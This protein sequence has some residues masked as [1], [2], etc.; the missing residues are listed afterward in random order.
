MIPRQTGKSFTLAD[1]LFQKYIEDGEQG[2]NYLMMSPQENKVKNLLIDDIMLEPFGGQEVLSDINSVYI[3][4]PDNFVKRKYKEWQENPDV[5]DNLIQQGLITDDLQYTKLFWG[6][7]ANTGKGS[8]EQ[9]HYNGRLFNGAELTLAGANNPN[10]SNILRGKKWKGVYIAE[11]GEVEKDIMSIFMPSVIK[12]GGWFWFDGTPPNR[13]KGNQ[14][15]YFK[16]IEPIVKNQNVKLAK[17]FGVSFYN[18][19][20]TLEIAQTTAEIM[21]GLEPRKITDRRMLAIGKLEDLFPY[22]W[23]G[24]EYFTR[25]QSSRKVPLTIDYLKDKDGNY[26]E[27]VENSYTDPKTK[28]RVVFYKYNLKP[29]PINTSGLA[30]MDESEYNREMQ[31]SFTDF[32]QQTF[33]LFSEANVIPHELFNP[34]IYNCFT[35]FDQGVN[36]NFVM[37]NPLGTHSATCIV[38]IALI[39][40]GRFYQYV[41][42][43]Y[44]YIEKPSKYNIAR[45][46]LDTLKAGKPIVLDNAILKSL[47]SDNLSVFNAIIESDDDLYN[48]SEARINKGIYKCIKR[49]SYSKAKEYNTWF[50]QTQVTDLTQETY[51]HPTDASQIGRKIMI[52]DKCTPI[53][54]YLHEQTMIIKG[55]GKSAKFDLKTERNDL[56]DSLTYAIDLVELHPEYLKDFN[57]FWARHLESRYTQYDDTDYEYMNRVQNSQK[58][59]NSWF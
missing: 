2:Y 16:F 55:E 11:M 28:E 31:M 30:L 54:N 34:T 57:S 26:I 12:Q 20:Q 8:R 51:R 38:H 50:S 3:K 19:S 35:G 42:Y 24:E 17:K 29:A 40:H 37:L 14:W 23:K 25:I 41:I 4:I 44:E 18:L 39:P 1:C 33:D 32:G 48:H 15:F 43:D 46:W 10:I 7:L 13:P 53:I 5:L 9:S 52:T 22:I 58:L 59:F 47:D 49:E 21:A 56:Y 6:D 45:C 27:N 36:S